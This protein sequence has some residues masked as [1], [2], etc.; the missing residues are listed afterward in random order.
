MSNWKE[1]NFGKIPH[2]W[3]TSTL[4]EICQL[5][6][7]G[8]HVS[9]KPVPSKYYM[10]SVKD[11]RYN[12]FDFSDCKTISKED[13]DFLVK[14]NCKPNYGDILLSKDG[15]NCLDII[16]VYK[17]KDEI[18]LLSSI[19]IARLKEGYHSDFYR[20]FLLSPNIQELMRNN[21]VSGSAIPRVILKDFKNVPIPIANYIEQ[22]AIAE[23]LSSLDDKIDLLQRQ[24][25]TLEQLAETL[26]KQWFVEE[27]D[28]NWETVKV[29]D[30][31]DINKRTIGKS[32]SFN[33]IEYLDTG[34]ITEGKIESFQKYLIT[35]APSRAQ[36]I[37]GNNDIVYSLVRPIQKHYGLLLDTK[38][39]TIASTGFCVISCEKISPYFV[40]LLLTQNETVEYF[41]MVAEGST[42]TY[43][44]LKP[45]DIADFEFQL[46]PQEKLNAFSKIVEIQWNKIKLNTNQISILS[47]LREMLLPKLMSGEVRIKWSEY[48]DEN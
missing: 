14:N 26:F 43:P 27:A 39:N 12:H 15:A 30:V 48:V 9:P 16:F 8:S 37:V 24:N 42:S 19:A 18:V 23:A 47:Q 22:N 10:A 21:F 1:T 28:G 45:S 17:Q 32:F 36:R 38:P 5:L 13:F 44:S 31:A 20:Y 29:S 7:D 25:K 41:E 6:T 3:E 2:E 46:P 40:Y 34:S 4:G 11:M 35:E 33:E